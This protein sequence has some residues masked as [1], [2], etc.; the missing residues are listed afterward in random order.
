[1][2]H[3]DFP[4]SEGAKFKKY[5]NFKGQHLETLDTGDNPTGLCFM[6]WNGK[7]FRGKEPQKRFVLSQLKV[8]TPEK[9]KRYLQRKCS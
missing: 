6:I 4:F 5:C 1:M 9:G 2:G 3:F 8:I 7:D